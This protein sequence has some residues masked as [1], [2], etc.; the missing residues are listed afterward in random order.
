MSEVQ[1]NG[2]HN[3]DDILASIR[4]II[5]SDSDGPTAIAPND[6]VVQEA[7]PAETSNSFVER[8]G[9]VAG[10]NFTPRHADDLS[11]L[12]EPTAAARGQDTAGPSVA[13]EA[14]GIPSSNDG[15]WPFKV[16]DEAATGSDLQGRIAALEPKSMQGIWGPEGL[17]TAQAGGSHDAL[18]PTPDSGEAGVHVSNAAVELDATGQMA[19][20]TGELP[21]FA[22]LDVVAKPSNLDARASAANAPANPVGIE[23]VGDGGAM[24]A[25]AVALGRMIDAGGSKPPSNEAKV[26]G[27]TAAPTAEAGNGAADV[28]SAIPNRVIPEVLPATDPISSKTATST[29]LEAVVLEA[30]QPML[31]EWIDNNLARLVDE[32]IESGI[33]RRLSEMNLGN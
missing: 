16:K 15:D 13:I 1:K 4:K 17:S 30:L 2:D 25:G 19:A 28:Q 3:M 32:K 8:A 7:T 5:S 33:A 10:G 21:V 24:A 9:A 14:R 29:S 12:L 26:E 22:P 27:V 18:V 6:V 11:D 31:R 23:T 20:N